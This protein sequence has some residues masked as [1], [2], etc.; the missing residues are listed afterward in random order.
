[1]RWVLLL[2]PQRRNWVT[3]QSYGFCK[4]LA[5]KQQAWGSTWTSKSTF[6]ATVQIHFPAVYAAVFRPQRQVAG[7]ACP[8]IPS[9]NLPHHFPSAPCPHHQT[10]DHRNLFLFLFSFFPLIFVQLTPPPACS[11]GSP[12]CRGSDSGVHKRPGKKS[13]GLGTRTGKKLHSIVNTEVVRFCS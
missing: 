5:D 2:P 6:W 4:V 8:C 10:Y 9:V 7:L 12:W 3:E 13:R 1:M 11:K